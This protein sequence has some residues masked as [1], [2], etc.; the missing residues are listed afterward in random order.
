MVWKS[1]KIDLVPFGVTFVFCV[2]VGLEQGILI[3]TAINLGMLLYS[4]A[5]PRIRI[6]KVQASALHPGIIV[7]IEMNHVSAA[8]FTTAYG[9]DNMI[10]SL[11]KHDHKVVLTRTK[12]EVLPVLFGNGCDLHIHS[13]S[14]DF[15]TFLQDITTLSKTPA[16]SNASS[17]TLSSTTVFKRNSDVAETS[18]SISVDVEQDPRG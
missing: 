7:V 14:M 8:D 15:D 1:K 11:Q 16:L 9:F 17:S 6:L 3:G 4:T 18:M 12:P 5:R 2:F 13:D 10:K